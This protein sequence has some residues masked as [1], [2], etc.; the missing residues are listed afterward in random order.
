MIVKMIAI[1]NKT[2]LDK[3]RE[4]CRIVAI[5]LDTLG[6]MIVP[7]VSTWEL[8]EKAE[9]IISTY[10]AEAAFK[11]YRM[12]GL[13]PYLFSICASINDEIVHG[14]SSKEKVLQEGDI[15]GIDVGVKKDGFYG[16][17]ARTFAVGKIDSQAQKLMQATELAL[18]RAIEQCYAGNRVG[19]IS[20]V[21][22]KTARENNLFVAE[23]LTGHGVGHKLHEEPLIPNEGKKG[24]GPRLAPGMTIAIEPM[25]NLGTSEVV[26]DGWV[27]RTADGS[28][29]AHFENTILITENEPEILTRKI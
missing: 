18:G 7:G 8:N 11:N 29:S 6:E 10:G 25:F 22:E 2:E 17:G 13:E 28:N 26:E 3:I 9:E 12:N 5:V 19:D 20:F 23:G 24:R 15:I 14:Y 16:D 4:S 1:N 21:I 27:F